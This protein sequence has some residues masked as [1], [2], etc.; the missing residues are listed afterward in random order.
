VAQLYSL[1]PDFPFVAS[2]HSQSY[3]G[4]IPVS[5]Q[6]QSYITTDGQVG[7]SVL[8]LGTHLELFSFF[9]YFLRLCLINKKL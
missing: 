2:Y 1:T 3:G 4:G 8:V 6:S 5:Y 9:N 7:Q